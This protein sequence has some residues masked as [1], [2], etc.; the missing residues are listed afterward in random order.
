MNYLI[1]DNCQKYEKAFLLH[2]WNKSKF[3]YLSRRSGL[4]FQLEGGFNGFP[5]IFANVG[6]EQAVEVEIDGCVADFQQVGNNAEFL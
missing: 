6:V 4:H 2:G 5:D 3:N 1:G